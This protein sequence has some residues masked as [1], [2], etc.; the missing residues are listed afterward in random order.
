MIH[1]TSLQRKAVFILVQ[2]KDE[3]FVNTGVPAGRVVAA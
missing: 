2:A 3:D 1:N